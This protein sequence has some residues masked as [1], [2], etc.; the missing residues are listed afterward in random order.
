MDS[1]RSLIQ[2][3]VLFSCRSGAVPLS[4][5]TG[6]CPEG[7]LRVFRILSFLG[8]GLFYVMLRIVEPSIPRVLRGR[9]G[10]LICRGIGFVW[11]AE[12]LGRRVHTRRFRRELVSLIPLRYWCACEGRLV[13]RFCMRCTSQGGQDLKDREGA[14]TARSLVSDV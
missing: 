6:G 9:R 1:F 13:E 4:A 11:S 3:I 7:R 5:L 2:L 8:D 12:R 10:V 14:G